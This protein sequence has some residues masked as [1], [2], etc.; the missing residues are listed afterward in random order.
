MINRVQWRMQWKAA[1]GAALLGLCSVAAVS[2]SAQSTQPAPADEP[3]GGPHNQWRRGQGMEDR[4]FGMLI[5][6]LSLTADQ[7]TGVKA[8]LDQQVT[9]MKALRTAPPAESG[10][11]APGTPEARQARFT[12]MTQ[13]REETET[14]I[15]ALLDENQKKTYA[16]MIAQ[17]K[18]AMAR[19]QS[20][21]GN[22]P[23]PDSQSPQL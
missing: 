21:D 1:I 22:G 12:Q 23:P 9:Q 2:Q 7:Q 14:K 15:S 4:E 6:R 13:I 20:R 5:R 3:S 18:Q 19:R 16:E 17:R 10:A 11:P 8:L